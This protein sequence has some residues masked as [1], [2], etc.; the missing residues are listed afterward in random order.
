MTAT[1]DKVFVCGVPR[2]GTTALTEMMNLHPNIVIGVERY[3]TLWSRSKE[4]GDPE[5]LFSADRFFQYFPEDTNVSLEGGLY[6]DLYARAAEKYSDAVIVGDKVPMLYKKI[7]FLTGHFPGCRIVVILR[8]P[9]D[10]AK[11]WQARADKTQDRW[12]E[13][14][15]YQKAIETWNSFLEI[16]Q[17]QKK[18]MGNDLVLL[19][20]ETCFAENGAS[21]FSKLFGLL[22]A[23]PDLTDAQRVFLESSKERLASPPSMPKEISDFVQKKAN[24]EL[25]KKLDDSAL[26]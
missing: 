2:S 7:P 15:G 12:P 9:E 19:R 8:G 3:K 22:G 6:G 16:I 26:R 23:S 25:F 18:R 10:V 17:R 14:N 4:L 11:S 5:H 1:T 13:E 21:I 20:Y 24:L